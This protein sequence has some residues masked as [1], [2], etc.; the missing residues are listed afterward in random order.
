[1]SRK[2]HDRNGEIIKKV[3]WLFHIIPLKRLRHTDKV[4]FD[5]MSLFH[6]F[7]GIDIVT[8]QANAK[9]PWDVWDFKNLWYMHKWQEDNLITLS[10]NRYVEL[11]TKENWKIERFEISHER[12]KWNWEIIHEG[13]AILGWPTWVFHRNYSPEGS[14]SMNFAVRDDLFDIDTEFNIYNL[15]TVSWKYEVARVWKLDQNNI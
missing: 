14:V 4:D 8:H 9:S 13:P 6:E 7:N 15:D 12:V 1:M 3:E 5:V 11:Y 2:I 10:G